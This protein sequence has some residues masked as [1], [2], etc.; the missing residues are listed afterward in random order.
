MVVAGRDIAVISEASRRQREFAAQARTLARVAEL[1]YESIVF[2]ERGPGQH[3]RDLVRA[4]WTVGPYYRD[5]VLPWPVEAEL[6]AVLGHEAGP[7]PPY[8]ELFASGKGF[9]DVEEARRFALARVAPAESSSPEKK[10]RDPF[11]IFLLANVSLSLLLR[12]PGADYALHSLGSLRWVSG[13]YADQAV[14]IA[15]IWF[16]F[17]P[18]LAAA[19]SAVRANP[20]RWP[21]LVG[22][23]FSLAL[24]LAGPRLIE[25]IGTHT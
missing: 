25:Q 24:W 15:F 10:D 6:G 20:I 18:G 17:V 21:L 11:A 23:A 5:L 2:A 13:T 9:T 22:G 16:G 1:G 19:Y 8:D 12:L 3:R 7:L 4:E 14:M